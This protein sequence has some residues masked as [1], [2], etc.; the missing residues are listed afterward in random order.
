MKIA[1][2]IFIILACATG[3]Y[4]AYLSKRASGVGIDPNWT[5]EPG[6]SDAS[7]AGWLAATMQ[8]ADASARF[9]RQAVRWSF[10]SVVLCAI[11]GMLGVFA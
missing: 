3:L 2:L 4:A 10:L 9:G 6:E 7:T 8:S 5:C 1:T 11:A